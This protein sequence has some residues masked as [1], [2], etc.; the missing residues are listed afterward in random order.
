[1]NLPCLVKL[2]SATGTSMALAAVYDERQ[3]AERNAEENAKNKNNNTGTVQTAAYGFNIVVAMRTVHHG[4]LS[5]FLQFLITLLC[6]QKKKMDLTS[7]RFCRGNLH[8]FKPKLLM[9]NIL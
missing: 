3:P 1:M 8:I 7:C 9:F 6:Y 4:V 5:P 2:D